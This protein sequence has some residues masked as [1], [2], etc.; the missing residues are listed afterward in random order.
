MRLDC[1]ALFLTC[2]LALPGFAQESIFVPLS[3]VTDPLRGRLF[4]GTLT[5]WQ[6]EDAGGTP[7]HPVGNPA[8]FVP[9]VKVSKGSAS[10]LLSGVPLQVFQQSGLRLRLGHQ[11]GQMVTSF[12][13]AAYS[14]GGTPGPVG[15]AGP[16]GPVGPAGPQGATGPQGDRGPVG[17][18]RPATQPFNYLCGRADAFFGA[19]VHHVGDQLRKRR[20]E[21]RRKPN[22][23]QRRLV[24]MST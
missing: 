9:G 18:R 22:R 14:A 10:L 3:G 5:S 13:F 15:P 19:L 6:I 21:M 1:R 11:Q 2:A 8:L 16:A 12:P 4:S 24:K 23:R 20:I 17:R 7:V